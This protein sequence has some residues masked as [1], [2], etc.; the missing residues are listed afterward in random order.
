MKPL[1]V[2]LL[3]TH[4]PAVVPVDHLVVHPVAHPEDGAVLVISMPTLV[5]DLN[6]NS[7]AR[8]VPR[9]AKLNAAVAANQIRRN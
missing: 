3:S 5:L 4:L 2:V 1:H 7:A 9:N 8:P 6:T